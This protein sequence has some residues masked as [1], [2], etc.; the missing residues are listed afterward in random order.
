MPPSPNMEPKRHLPEF[1]YSLF[2]HF[3]EEGIPL[4]LAGGW[5]VCFHGYSRTTLDLDYICARTRYDPGQI[6]HDELRQMCHRYATPEAFEQI[7]GS[8]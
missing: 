4:V 8:E 2:Q 1:A 6:G 3:A 7:L 5:A